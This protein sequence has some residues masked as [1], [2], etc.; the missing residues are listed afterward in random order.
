MRLQACCLWTCAIGALSL[1]G[2]S[3][4]ECLLSWRRPVSLLLSLPFV[5]ALGA[6]WLGQLLLVADMWRRPALADTIYRERHSLVTKHVRW[7]NMGLWASQAVPTF[8]FCLACYRLTGSGEI[9]AA[10]TGQFS[11]AFLVT[12]LAGQLACAARLASLLLAN[13]RTVVTSALTATSASQHLLQPRLHALRCMTAQLR[14]AWRRNKRLAL[15]LVCASALIYACLTVCLGRPALR[16]ALAVP[17]SPRLAVRLMLLCLHLLMSASAAAELAR[18]WLGRPEAPLVLE[19]STEFGLPEEV[20]GPAMLSGNCPTMTDGGGQGCHPELTRLLA[21]SALCRQLGEPACR[22]AVFAISPL[23]GRPRVWELA[24]DE[25]RLRLGCLLAGLRDRHRQLR[26]EG[27]LPGRVAMQR[28][29]LPPHLRARLHVT[30]PLSPPP[31]PPCSSAKYDQQ[32]GVGDGASALSLD[33]QQR[34]AG[35]ATL[36]GFVYHPLASVAAWLK[37][38]LPHSDLLE[39]L[40]PCQLHVLMVRVLCSLIEAS[41]TEDEFGVVQRDLPE[42]LGLLLRLGRTLEA[43]VKADGLDQLLLLMAPAAR[44]AATSP[45]DSD[46]QRRYRP[47]SQQANKQLQQFNYQ[48]QL[49]L[50]QAYDTCLRLPAALRE[51]CQHGLQSIVARFGRSLLELN[52]DA[53]ARQS[54]LLLFP[55]LEDCGTS[56]GHASVSAD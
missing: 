18:L 50:S 24:S 42:L 49:P 43:A 19:A 10:G 5:S 46:S 44:A 23:A 1:I 37:E 3:L 22:R 12:M 51:A 15:R 53:D 34:R 6:T 20:T 31:T 13:G 39:L 16:S 55:H 11:D 35:S 9:F 8:L 33:G 52:L 45:S 26:S 4:A 47:A 2:L 21:W 27:R 48:H 40:A 28:A 41:Y 54:L 36:G 14:D 7:R 56:N 30:D 17:M 25:A 29:L 38:P 32:P